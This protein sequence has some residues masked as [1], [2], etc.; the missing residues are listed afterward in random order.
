MERSVKNNRDHVIKD[1][2]GSCDPEQAGWSKE[3]GVQATGETCVSHFSP[4]QE[5]EWIYSSVGTLGLSILNVFIH[6]AVFVSG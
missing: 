1:W 2:A 4:I 6:T 5:T 3:G